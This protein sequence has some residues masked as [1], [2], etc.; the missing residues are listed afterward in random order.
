MPALIRYH[1]PPARRESLMAQ[2]AWLSPG[3]L[4]AGIMIGHLIEV[5]VR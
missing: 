3:L 2:V 5:A 1:R 4:L